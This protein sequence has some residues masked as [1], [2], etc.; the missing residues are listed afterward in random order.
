MVGSHPPYGCW[1]LSPGPQLRAT[2]PPLQFF[3]F[4]LPTFITATTSYLPKHSNYIR[5]CDIEGLPE[6]AAEFRRFEE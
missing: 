1:E 2:K 3:F 6:A 4:L 5:M